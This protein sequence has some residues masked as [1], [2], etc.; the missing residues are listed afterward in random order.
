MKRALARSLQERGWQALVVLAASSRVPDLAAFVGDIHIG[1]SFLVATPDGEIRL[2]FLT[3][4][5]RQEA[6]ASGCGLL[7]PESLDV[8]KLRR[9]SRTTAEFWQALVIRAVEACD[10][11]P[12]PIAIAGHFPAGTAFEV[13]RCLERRGWPCIAGDE[14][15]RLCRKR[16][17]RRQI[18]AAHRAA[19]G[20]MEAFHRVASLLAAA[21]GR[22]GELWL[23]GERLRVQRLRR[24]IAE[25]MA[26]HGLEQPEGN[27]VAAGSD[28]AIPHTPGCSERTLLEGES[29]VVDLYPR[30]FLFA[31]CT[32]TFCVG[33]TTA[34]LKAAHAA[35]IDSLRRSRRAA[36][37]GKRGWELQRA[38]C[39]RLGAAGYATPLTR[40]DATTGYVHGLGHGVGFELHEYPS[41]RETTG[42][43]GVL[44]TGDLFTL[45]PGLYD[46]E[47]GWGVRLEDLFC[48]T[49]GGLVNLTPLPYELD[50]RAWGDP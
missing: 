50:P 38:V 39:E 6:A 21:V 32:R 4:M 35:V 44:E 8:T 43:E 31:D 27:I 37:P 5:E 1:Q 26:S 18:E 33:R 29:I 12:G 48:L 47:A 22:E 28:A 9:D 24:A 42:P 10:V 13:G 41:F 34:E 46:P 3:A 16:K 30:G 40:P 15:V 14:L 20:A 25:C 7:T 49:D 23:E 19:E 36:S 17:T 2:A 11:S 45:E